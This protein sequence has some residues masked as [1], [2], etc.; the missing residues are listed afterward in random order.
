MSKHARRKFPDP[1]HP[2]SLSGPVKYSPPKGD[3][4]PP[5]M[6]DVATLR[7]NRILRL[8]VDRAM[9]KRGPGKT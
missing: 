4:Q 8:L 3:D 5:R 6:L 7:S 2:A 9:Q 1:P